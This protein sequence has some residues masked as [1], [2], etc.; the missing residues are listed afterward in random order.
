MENNTE[1][2]EKSLMFAAPFSFKKKTQRS[3]SRFVETGY[4]SCPFDRDKQQNKNTQ[5]ISLGVT[6]HQG[7]PKL[8]G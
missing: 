7:L 6:F 1:Y 4:F 5:T 8:T 2:R 3:D